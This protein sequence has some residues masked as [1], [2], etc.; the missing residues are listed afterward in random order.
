MT[1]NSFP[2]KVEVVII[3]AGPAGST[4]AYHLARLGV[5][6]VL[7]DKAKF[8]RGKTCGGGINVRTQELIPFDI[9]PVVEQVITRIS[10]TCNFEEEFQRRYPEPLMVTVIRENFDHLLVQQAEQAGAKFYDGTALLSLIPGDGSTKVETSRGSCSA[11]YAIGAD[12]AQS[13]VA[14]NL[15]LMQEASYMLAMHSEAPTSLLPHWEQDMIHIDWGSLKRTYAYLFPKKN[16]LSVGAGGINIPTTKIKNYHR[17]FL[18]T[19]WRKEEAL[20]F[21]AA[22]FMVPLRQKRSPIQLRRCLLL[23]DAAGLADPF[24]GEGI[25]SAIRSAQI[26]SSVLAEALKN[27]WNSLKPYQEA[28][29]GELMPE[30]EC[31]RLFRGLFN[32]RPSFYHQRIAHSV[33]WWNAM[34]KIMRGERTF[35]DIKKKLRILGSVL[36]RM[37]R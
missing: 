26:A 23:G 10:F 36:L 28:I 27:G 16:F 32:L 30:L 5:D 6:V 7:V 3:G 29:D 33:R 2:D 25:Y 8:P 13:T 21:S 19:Q 4:L 14:K 15:G 1:K 37:A 18:A 35:L 22:G 20:P 17:A 34:A 31:A 11:K 12:G 24:T 9:S